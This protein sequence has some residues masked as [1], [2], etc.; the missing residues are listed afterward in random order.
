LGYWYSVAR[1]LRLRAA[2]FQEVEAK[3]V[4]VEFWGNDVEG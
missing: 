3:G 2:V 1:K 4:R